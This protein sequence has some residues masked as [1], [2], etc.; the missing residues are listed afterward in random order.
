LGQEAW[1]TAFQPQRAKVFY[2]AVEMKLT[3]LGIRVC[4]EPVVSEEMAL[5][6]SATGWGFK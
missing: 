6:R 5:T 2:P 3:E 1:W 4:G